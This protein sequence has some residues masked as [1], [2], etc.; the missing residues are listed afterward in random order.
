MGYTYKNMIRLD[1]KN[2]K[3]YC[4]IVLRVTYQREYILISINEKIK[5]SEWNSK[6]EVPKRICTKRITI[7]DLLK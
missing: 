5:V 7:I 4:P 3:G 6:D 1:K 2:K